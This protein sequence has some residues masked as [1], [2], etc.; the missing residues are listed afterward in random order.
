MCYIIHCN[1]SSNWYTFTRLQARNFSFISHLI[2]KGQDLL[3]ARPELDQ[4]LLQ[5]I[6]IIHKSQASGI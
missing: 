2:N 4:A 1:K 6:H 3:Q 5:M